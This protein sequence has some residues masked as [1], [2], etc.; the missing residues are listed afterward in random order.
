MVPELLLVAVD[1]N[2]SPLRYPRLGDP[3]YRLPRAFGGLLREMAA[4]LVPPRLEDT[5]RRVGLSAAEVQEAARFFVRH[6]LLVPAADHY[7]ALGVSADADAERIREHYHLLVRLF[8]PDRVA[9][10]GDLEGLEASRLNVAYRVLRDEGRRAHY[11]AELAVAGSG[12]RRGALTLAAFRP[13]YRAAALLGDRHGAERPRSAATRFVVGAALGLAVLIALA[14]VLSPA[15]PVLRMAPELA[16]RPTPPPAY[17]GGRAAESAAASGAGGVAPEAGNAGGGEDSVV[18]MRSAPLEQAGRPEGPEAQPDDRPAALPVAVPREGGAA[19]REDLGH[20]ASIAGVSVSPASR[21]APVGAVGS[22]GERGGVS[23]AAAPIPSQVTQRDA[24]PEGRG[25]SGPA[26]AFDARAAGDKDGVPG[27]RGSSSAASEG[28]RGAPG[29]SVGQSV[30][31]AL[32]AG[33]R[34]EMPSQGRRSDGTGGEQAEAVAME[35]AITATEMSSHM[36][37]AGVIGAFEA[38]Y[39]GGD[40]S[41]LAALFVPEA[42]INEGVGRGLVQ[43]LYADLFRRVPER[44]LTL[45]PLRWSRGPLGR[46]IAEGDV[47]V[48]TRPRGSR[49][50]HRRSGTIRFEL[51]PAGER[52]QI[53]T[54]IYDLGSK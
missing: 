35:A 38:A 50:W 53:S 33:V 46:W 45:G 43:T 48:D 25:G 7:R 14:V 20:R 52:Y 42:R 30:Q 19:P 16:D 54:M 4:A 8:H 27:A 17:L 36:P 24:G 31:P 37:P 39:E 40:P 22:S 18:A 9:S 15:R 1:F 44:S 34:D 26:P 51:T 32:S 21:L 5:A 49:R 10:G 3:Q 13:D 6:V 2:R 23:F 47:L 29:D 12:D 28:P 11:D 41:R